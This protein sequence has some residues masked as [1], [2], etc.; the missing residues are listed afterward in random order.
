MHPITM[1]HF[2]GK[3]SRLAELP[4]TAHQPEVIIRRS[5]RLSCHAVVAA[6]SAVPG[7]KVLAKV[8]EKQRVAAVL[9]VGAV[10]LHLQQAHVRICS[11]PPG[12]SSKML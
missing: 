7:S 6:A 9:C 5:P 4:M 12:R 2:R 11:I 10:V 8:G 3:L 1:S